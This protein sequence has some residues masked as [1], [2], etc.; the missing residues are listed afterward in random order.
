MKKAVVTAIVL[1]LMIHL[2]YAYQVEPLSLRGEGIKQFFGFRIVSVAL[3]MPPQILSRDVLSNC[4]KKLVV[5][6][7]QNVSKEEL[8]RQTSHG[9]KI[10]VSSWE[11]TYLLPKLKEMNRKYVDVHKGD[12]IIVEY[13]PGIGLQLYVNDLDKGII[14]GDDLARAFFAIWVGQHP[15][16]FKIKKS[17]LDMGV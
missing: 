13:F 9:V 7:L 14:R 6:Y 17:L 8:Q 10:N 4:P 11:Y 16:D 12:K 3:Y 15:V 2:S 1:G 5:T